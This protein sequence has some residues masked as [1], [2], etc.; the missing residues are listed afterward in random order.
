V[1]SECCVRLLFSDVAASSGDE[2]ISVIAETAGI[3]IERIVSPG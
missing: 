2:K 3:K 1:I